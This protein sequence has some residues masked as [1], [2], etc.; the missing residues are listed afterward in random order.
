MAHGNV[1]KKRLLATLFLLLGCADVTA[2]LFDDRVFA[3]NST[4]SLASLTFITEEY[5][6]YNYLDGDRLMGSSVELLE[7]ML[8][9]RALPWAGMTSA[10]TLGYAATNSP[11]IGPTPSCFPRPARRAENRGFTG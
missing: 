11:C 3:D 4:V 7:A 5:P 2:S 1:I 8:A 6:P 9:M 10:T